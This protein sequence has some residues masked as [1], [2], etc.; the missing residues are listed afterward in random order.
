MSERAVATALPRGTLGKASPVSAHLGE[1]QRLLKAISEADSH[2]K[3][4]LP[5]PIANQKT[6]P[7]RDPSA[8]GALLSGQVHLAVCGLSPIPW[9][10]LRTL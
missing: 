5:H 4:P 8:S 2:Q 10:G 1:E 9:L 3:C 7:S 6:M